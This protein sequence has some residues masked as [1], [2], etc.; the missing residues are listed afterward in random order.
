MNR[1]NLVIKC[2][3]QT[4]ADGIRICISCGSICVI[5]KENAMTCRDCKKQFKFK[6]KQDGICL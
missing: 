5:I 3:E 1:Q 6:E 4:M 2:E